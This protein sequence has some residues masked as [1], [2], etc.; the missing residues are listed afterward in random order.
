MAVADALMANQYG[1]KSQSRRR[2]R[3]IWPLLAICNSLLLHL[4]TGVCVLTMVLTMVTAGRDGNSPLPDRYAQGR[5][6]RHV[7]ARAPNHQCYCVTPP[8]FP[9]SFYCLSSTQSSYYQTLPM[10]LLPGW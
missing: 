9:C 8:P 1:N 7:F 4:Y 5:F 6:I 3:I 10:L 2:S